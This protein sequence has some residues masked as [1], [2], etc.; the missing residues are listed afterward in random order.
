MNA[1]REML[2]GMCAIAACIFV[3]IFVGV[4][5]E[6]SN[7]VSDAMCRSKC[8]AAGKLESRADA[9]QCF[10]R[11]PCLLPWEPVDEVRA[12]RSGHAP[13]YAPCIPGD[14]TTHVEVL[15]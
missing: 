1:S 9:G 8:F 10:C 2:I 12:P 11:M 6:R 7:P 4:R 13:A 3:G 14:G 15:P 5:W